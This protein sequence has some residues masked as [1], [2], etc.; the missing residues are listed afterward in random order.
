MR[1][2]GEWEEGVVLSLPHHLDVESHRHQATPGQTGSGTPIWP[3]PDALSLAPGWEQ[4]VSGRSV[5]SRSKGA[6][7]RRP[8]LYT[9]LFPFLH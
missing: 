6:G 5:C 8:R 3:K 2:Q 7:S 1:G 4:S 9:R